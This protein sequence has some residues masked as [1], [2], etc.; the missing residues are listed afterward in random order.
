[1]ADTQV[2]LKQLFDR[3]REDDSKSIQKRNQQPSQSKYQEEETIK[4]GD[5]NREE[6]FNVKAYLTADEYAK[7]GERFP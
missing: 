5:K 2:D 1:M 4:I 3:K 7:F 6:T